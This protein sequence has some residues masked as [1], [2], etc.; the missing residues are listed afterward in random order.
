MGKWYEQAKY[1]NSFQGYNQKCGI[2]T[3]RIVNESIMII[4]TQLANM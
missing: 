2:A 4:N 1:P 3:Y